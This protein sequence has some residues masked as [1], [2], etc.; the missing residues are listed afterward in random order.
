MTRCLAIAPTP[1]CAPL[2]NSAAHS[3]PTAVPSIRLSNYP[4]TPTCPSD[5]PRPEILALHLPSD[6]V[7]TLIHRSADVPDERLAPGNRSADVP[8]ERLGPGN[9]SVDVPEKLPGVPRTFRVPGN[10]S[11]DVLDER[12]GPRNG[13]VDVPDKCLGPGNRSVDELDK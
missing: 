1:S 3:V 12:L 13:S 7:T 2:G 4:T 10:R 11:A 6:F 5:A 8:D 9:G